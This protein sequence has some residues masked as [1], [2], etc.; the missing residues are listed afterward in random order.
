MSRSDPATTPVVFCSDRTFAP[1]AAVATLSLMMNN[2]DPL[3]IYWIVRPEDVAYAQALRARL[4]GDVHRMEIMGVDDSAFA[5]WGEHFHVTRGAYIRLLIPDLLPHD[6]ALY[7]DGDV[8]ALSD[9][10]PLLATDLRGCPIGGVANR[11]SEE[12]P[13][14]TVCKDTFINSGVLLMDLAALRRDRFF[15]ACEA[16]Y[17]GHKDDG[18][19]MDQ[20]VINV[21]AEGR[22]CLLDA[23]WNCQV[24]CHQ[25][26]DKDWQALVQSGTVSIVHFLGVVK[27]W[28]EWSGPAIAQDWK[29]YADQIG[30]GPE[31]YQAVN[32]IKNGYF[33]AMMHDLNGEFDAA[34]AMKARIIARFMKLI[35]AERLAGARIPFGLD[36]KPAQDGQ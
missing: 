1:Y 7:L 6:R 8:L 29:Q 18:T 12:L 16:I 22:K 26:S 21:Y 5:G 11:R 17:R 13:P 10:G 23:R 3:L 24:R 32:T 15:E 27:P 19:W 2:H 20:E 14:P 9:I 34:S 28:Q 35:P 30:L 4:P 25:T 31:H 33:R 36:E